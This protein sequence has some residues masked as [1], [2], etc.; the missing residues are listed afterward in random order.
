MKIIAEN[1]AKINGGSSIKV[2]FNDLMNKKVETRT[3]EEIISDTIKK[4]GLIKE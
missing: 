1:T 4:G 3:A 2:R